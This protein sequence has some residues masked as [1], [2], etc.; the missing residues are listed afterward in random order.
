MNR[1]KNR[2]CAK[3][4]T[5]GNDI[6]R[7]LDWVLTDDIFAHIPLHGNVSWT[8]IGIV[9]LAL[10]WVF[11]PMS[12]LGDA[13]DSAVESMEH[14]FGSTPVRSYQGLTGALKKYSSQLLPALSNRIQKKMEVDLAIKFRIGPYLALALDGSVVNVPR[15]QANEERFCKSRHG[16]KKKSWKETRTRYANRKRS[17][18]APVKSHYDPQPVGPQ[19]WLTLLWNIGLQ[20]PWAWKIGPSNSSERAHLLEMLNTHEFPENTL[21]CADAG[22]FGYDFWNGIVSAGH[23]FLIRVGG[24]VRLLKGLGYVRESNGIVYCWPDVACRKGHLPL[25]LRL[26]CFH[27]GRSEVY[28]VTNILD[29][30]KLT[31]KLA[32]DI[33]RR[34][35]GIELQFRALKQTYDRTKLRARTPDCALVELNWSLLGLTILQL[36]AAKEQTKPAEPNTKTSVAMALRIIRHMIDHCM[37]QR[38]RTKSLSRQLG[39]ATTDTYNRSRKKKNRNF[40]RRKA[41]PSAKPPTI[42]VATTKQKLK[43]KKLHDLQA[44]A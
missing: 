19:I 12:A 26:L 33:Y 2:E 39:E 40:P 18:F 1:E 8:P 6:R 32:S 36:L 15:T 16:K 9:R 22:F 3:V 29:N 38:P 14:L 30:K 13:A 28:L 27:D 7:A 42:I 44:S 34:R 35:W 31:D 17:D 41:E 23:N 11:C 20:I 21:F 43:C 4:G 5:H 37:E 24:N 25:V 10:L